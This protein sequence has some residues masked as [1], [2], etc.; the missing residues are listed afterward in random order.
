MSTSDSIDIDIGVTGDACGSREGDPLRMR[1]VQ[2][3]SVPKP[4]H[5]CSSSHQTE[6]AGAL[7]ALLMSRYDN[8]SLDQPMAVVG[9]AFEG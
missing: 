6:D 8:N 5:R 3:R 4:A 2:R 7:T 1:A 9:S